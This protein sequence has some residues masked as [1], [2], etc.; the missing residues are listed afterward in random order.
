MIS[1]SITP[2]EARFL[3][4]LRTCHGDLECVVEKL[5]MVPAHSITPRMPRLSP[6]ELALVAR[7]LQG[8]GLIVADFRFNGRLRTA[9]LTIKGS[10][11]LNDYLARRNA[12]AKDP[13]YSSCQ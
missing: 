9:K 2:T 7:R 8:K 13:N 10:Q 4:S 3:E 12:A 1:C 11:V 6:H 5:N